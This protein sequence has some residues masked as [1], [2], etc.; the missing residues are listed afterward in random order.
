[1]KLSDFLKKL[2]VDVEEEIEDDKEETTPN[3]KEETKPKE[4]ELDSRD[5]L[6]KSLQD[7]ISKYKTTISS[8]D[9]IINQNNEQIKALKEMQSVNNPIEEQLTLQEIIAKGDF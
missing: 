5:V 3:P 8:K 7:E 6:I 4:E 1:M 9:E 2:G